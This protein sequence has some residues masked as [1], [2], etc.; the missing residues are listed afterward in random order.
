MF[1]TEAISR[2]TGFSAGVQV[3]CDGVEIGEK[4]GM[5]ISMLR[6]DS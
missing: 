6:A 4:D 2:V 1:A 5:L 3:G